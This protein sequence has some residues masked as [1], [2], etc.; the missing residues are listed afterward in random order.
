MKKPK[1][2]ILA[3]VLLGVSFCASPQKKA[4]LDNEKNPQYQ[5]EKAV[6]ALQYG[7]PDEALKYVGQALSL[8]PR[9]YQAL[10]LLGAIQLRKGNYAESAEALEKCLEIRTDA[11][12][13]HNNLGKAYENLGQKDKAEA[14]FK[15]AYALN[16]DA[17]A[18]FNLARLYYE[19]KQLEPALE[20]IKKAIQGSK[21]EAAYFNLQG[22]ILNQL[23]RYPE[24]VSS[25]LAGLALLPGDVNMRVNLGLTYANAKQFDKARETFEQVLPLIKDQDLIKRV[26]EYLQAIKK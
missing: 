5:F 18:A 26:K 20:H 12:E 3:A 24:A 7:L 8:D 16:G 11:P 6:V 17:L 22:I 1:I 9:H 14:E 10:R 25:F 4:A 13:V 15:K 21:G 23:G 19:R 2:A